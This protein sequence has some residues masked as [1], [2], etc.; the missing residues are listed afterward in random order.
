MYLD[1]SAVTRLGRTPH[2]EQ[3]D[4]T[5]CRA[6]IHDGWDILGNTHGGYL[7]A[8]VGR[9]IAEVTGR[10]DPMT[11]TAHYLSPG[12]P[13]PVSIDVETV[14]EGKRFSTARATMLNADSKPVITALATYGDLSEGGEFPTWID[15]AEPDVLP[16]HECVEMG[17]QDTTPEFMRRVDLLIDPRDLGFVFGERTGMPR[18]RGWFR[19]GDGELLTTDALL[20]A[21]DAFPPTIF[22]LDLP[23]GWAPT[24]ELT[25]HIR[26]VPVDDWLCC[27]VRTR[28]VSTGFMEVDGWYWDAAGTL[29]AQSRQ[30]AL[31]PRG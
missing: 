14:K 27:E 12:R 19:L 23:M 21:I 18:Y 3:P 29:V 6:T 16:R 9:S 11:I 10:P 20:V 22:N 31:L 28:F 1:A 8:I 26:A 15:G 2:E 13:G 5:R 24:V 25:G 17:A 7:L 4:S 30:L